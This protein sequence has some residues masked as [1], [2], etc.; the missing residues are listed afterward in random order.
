MQTKL[1]KWIWRILMD[2]E[3]ILRKASFN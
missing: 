3:D 1:G 2:K